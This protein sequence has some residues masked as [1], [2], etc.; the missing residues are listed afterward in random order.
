MSQDDLTA[1]FTTEAQ[2]VHAVVEEIDD[3]PEAF[4]RAV[5]LAPGKSG[6]LVA[7]PG[8]APDRSAALAGLCEENDL[9]LVTENVRDQGDRFVLGLTAVDWG[10]A[11]TGTL[12]LDAA[13][14]D[15]RLATMLPEIHAAVLPASR[16]KARSADLIPEL[17]RLAGSPP[18]YTTFI[19][20]ASRTA[21]IERELTI[22]VHGPG[23][24][25]IFLVTGQEG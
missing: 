17:K 12:V 6:G 20:G 3:W 21:D 13:S 24:L 15:L 11:E 23:E 10:I 19:T 25:H 16:I 2:K 14:E 5:R 7:A 18:G 1:I 22:G 4:R 9:V 8:L